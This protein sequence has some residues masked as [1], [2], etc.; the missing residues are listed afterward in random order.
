MKITLQIGFAFF[1]TSSVGF[2]GH[3][4]SSLA[5]VC[6]CHRHREDCWFD[7]AHCYRCLPS[8]HCCYLHHLDIVFLDC[9]DAEEVAVD[10]ADE[11]TAG[12]V[13]AAANAAKAENEL[14]VDILYDRWKLLSRDDI[15][16]AVREDRWGDRGRKIITA[17]VSITRRGRSN[18]IGG[19]LALWWAEWW[20]KNATTGV[21]RGGGRS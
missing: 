7:R 4:S 12:L 1:T 18:S 9:F 21:A 5:K 11:D 13:A 10:V 15:G 19:A 2:A 17:C 14:G 8:Q 6:C 16:Q 20:R 3:S